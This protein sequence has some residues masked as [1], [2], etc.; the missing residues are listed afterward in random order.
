MPAVE[1]SEYRKLCYPVVIN[2]VVAAIAKVGFGVGRHDEVAKVNE[3]SGVASH[4][5]QEVGGTNF[6]TS[7]SIT[8]GEEARYEY[9]CD[10]ALEAAKF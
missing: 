1:E 7:A 10:A 9:S 4:S 5:I 3:Q 2:T 6:F 8:R